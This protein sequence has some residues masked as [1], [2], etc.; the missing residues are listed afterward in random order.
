M[1][2]TGEVSP[3][4]TYFTTDHL[5]YIMGLN[6]VLCNDY[7]A[8]KRLNHSTVTSLSAESNTVCSDSIMEKE[9]SPE[10]SLYIC[11]TRRYQKNRSSDCL[12]NIPC[13]YP[14]LQGGAKVSWH[15]VLKM[16]PLMPRVFS[17]H[18]LQQGRVI[19]FGICRH[20][21]V[22]LLEVCWDELIEHPTPFDF[23]FPT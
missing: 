8:P 3:G 18:P 16:F 1:V 6:P 9:C 21:Y 15:S 13:L 20:P 12:E 23:L 17:Q 5:R 22:T 10:M 2:L 19:S 14:P 11:N 7:P 4:V